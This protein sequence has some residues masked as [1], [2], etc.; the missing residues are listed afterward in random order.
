MG[1]KDKAITEEK[2]RLHLNHGKKELEGEMGARKFA[3]YLDG[4]TDPSCQE[5][6]DSH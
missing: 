3:I 6:K 5:G 2:R 4:G 1:Y